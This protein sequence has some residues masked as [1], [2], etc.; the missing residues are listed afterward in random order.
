MRRIEKDTFLRGFKVLSNQSFDLFL[1]AGASISSGIPSGGDLVW[2]F[3]RELLSVS[4]KI[5]GKK[6]QDLK[7]ESNKKIIQS[8]FA[9]ED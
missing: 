2:Q 8:Y 7:I 6:F 3:K 9:E 5:N 4:G 1:G